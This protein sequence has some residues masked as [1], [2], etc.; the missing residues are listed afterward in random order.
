MKFDEQE[1]TAL[2]DAGFSVADNSKAAYVEAVVVIA[3]IATRNYA[4]RRNPL[5]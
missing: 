1:R 5:Q 3:A 4:A 2:T